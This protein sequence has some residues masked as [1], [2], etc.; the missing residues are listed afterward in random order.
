MPRGA[1]GPA[2]EDSVASVISLISQTF[3]GQGGGF[4]SELSWQNFVL[5]RVEKSV[6]HWDSQ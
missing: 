4:Y 5:L 6:C 2:E 1:A 3:Q